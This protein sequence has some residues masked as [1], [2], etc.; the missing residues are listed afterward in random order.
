MRKRKKCLYNS[1]TPVIRNPDFHYRA[2]AIRKGKIYILKFPRGE[3]PRHAQHA[4]SFLE[5]NI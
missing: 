4:Q 2:A 1:L 3:Q 5:T